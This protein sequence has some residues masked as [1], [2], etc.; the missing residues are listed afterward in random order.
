MLLLWSL[1]VDIPLKVVTQMFE[2]HQHPLNFN[3]TVFVALNKVEVII[4]H[5]TERCV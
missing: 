2:K 3:L 4:L 5:V 1:F